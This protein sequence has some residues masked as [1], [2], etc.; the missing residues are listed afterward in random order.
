MKYAL[1]LMLFSITFHAL[2]QTETC[3][4][5]VERA[6]RITE[7]SCDETGNNQVCYGHFSLEAD[8]Y[9]NDE[10]FEFEEP[11]HRQQINALR[12]LRLSAMDE[13][14]GTWGIA[15]MEVE[16]ALETGA[17]EDVTFVMFGDVELNNP[18]TLFPIAATRSMN[19]R[20]T[21]DTSGPIIGTL[22]EGNTLTASGRLEDSS[23]VRVRFADG[24]GWVFRDLIDSEIDLESL[25]VIDPDATAAEDIAY[26]PMQVFYM[27][28]A[29]QDAPCDEAPNSG[30]MI[31]TPEGAAEVTLL[32]NEVDISLRATAFV[33]AEPEGDMELFVL[34]GSAVVESNGVSHTLIPGTSLRVPLDENGLANGAPTEPEPFDI[35]ALQALPTALL[36]TPVEIPEPLSVS[37]GVPADGQ[38]AFNWG[39]TEMTCENGETVDFISDGTTSTITA[40][41][42][43]ATLTVLLTPYNR[44]S[45]GVYEAIFADATGNLHRHTLTVSSLDRINGT[46]EISY[47]DIGCELTV[48]FTFTLVGVN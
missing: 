1:L 26:G 23:W 32:M 27:Q 46:A 28:T 15:L 17:A 4:E 14:L 21:P 44:V 37:A 13:L 30:M 19:V 10:S 39:V 34:E 5:I 48:P 24:T 45:Q 25:A 20:A 2:A 6:L 41:E 31:Q 36:D 43:G 8:P 11:G 38:W 22:D 7:E 12:S 18:A 33:Q 35:S 3:P 47:V 29:Q 9:V 16:A 42:D 40:S